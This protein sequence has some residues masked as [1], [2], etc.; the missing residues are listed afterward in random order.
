M[1]LGGGLRVILSELVAVGLDPA[2][3]CAG[4]GVVVP[5]DDAAPFG[6]G[7]LTRVLERAEAMTGDPLLGLHMAERARGRGVLSYLART[8]RTVGDGLQT[9]ER[10]AGSTWSTDAVRLERDGE[11]T[12]VRVRL[13]VPTPRH[14]LDYVVARIAISLRRSGA[15]ARRV[16]FAH[17]PGGPVSEYE[18]ILRCPVHFRQPETGLVLEAD[19]LARPLRTASPEAADA[20]A[21]ALV[22]QTEHP[23]SPVAARLAAAVEDALAR[24]RRLDRETLAH[25]LGMS[26]RT[27]ARRLATEG[28]HFRDIVDDVR[29]A[30]ARRLIGE[31]A[32]ALGD[33]A[34]RVGFADLAGFGKAFRRWFGESPSV[35]RSRR[36]PERPPA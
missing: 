23:G 9:F 26:G 10:F 20:L 8:Q 31:D 28:R 32:L 12:F 30:L 35:A 18:R 3:V 1:S 29:R 17:A 33:V 27:L 34:A 36:S 22:R 19:D 24:G 13:G 4:A 11:E 2:V 6:L 14:V 7:E 16:A 15:G 21:A 5:E 25:S